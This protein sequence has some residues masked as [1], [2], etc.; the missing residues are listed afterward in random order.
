MEQEG[1][2]VQA[3]A[4]AGTVAPSRFAQ[5]IRAMTESG[6]RHFSVFLH[7]VYAAQDSEF[8]RALIARTTSVAVDGGLSVFESLGVTPHIALGDFDTISDAPARLAGKCEVI[9]YPCEKDKSDGQLALE[10]ALER[11]ATRVTLCGYCGGDETDHI[12][13]NLILLVLGSRLANAQATTVAISAERPGERVWALENDSLEITGNAGDHVSI[14]PL[15]AAISVTLSG[16]RYPAESITVARGSTV[17]FRNVMTGRQATVK[18]G[19]AALI[20]WRSGGGAVGLEDGVLG[21]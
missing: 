1:S 9:Q 14:A 4:R 7:G 15:D 20:F 8:Y 2:Q 12:F 21:S 6:A 10:L 3:F 19:G 17:T 11:G 5:F 16:M 13:G 18:V